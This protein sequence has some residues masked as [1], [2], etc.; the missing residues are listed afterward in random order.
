M[1][2]TPIIPFPPQSSRPTPEETK[3][4]MNSAT[5]FLRTLLPD[6]TIS[7]PPIVLASLQKDDRAGQ[8]GI[9]LFDKSID[10]PIV[11]IGG[12]W[13]ALVTTADLASFQTQIDALNI[14]IDTV[15]TEIDAIDIRVDYLEASTGAFGGFRAGAPIAISDLSATWQKLSVFTQVD[16]PVLNTIFD[17]ATDSFQVLKIGV[18]SVSLSINF[19]YV[20]SSNTQR[21]TSIRLRNTTTNA[22][23]NIVKIQLQEKSDEASYAI[24]MI[25]NIPAPALSTPWIAEMSGD[26]AVTGV[27]IQSC[28]VSIALVGS[29]P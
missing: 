25:V 14:R 15:E 7:A 11:S 5:T 3:A 26:A 9:M 16:V 12:V 13:Q 19:T 27:T 18:Y 2:K 20:V 29:L 22:T 4:W 23:S 24:T 17:I 1:A 10:K 8:D 28:V 21:E 6:N